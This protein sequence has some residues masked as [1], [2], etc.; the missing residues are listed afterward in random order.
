MPDE[1]IER[2]F[3][4]SSP[5]QLSVSNIDGSVEIRSGAD[6]NIHIVAVKH[7]NSGNA[8]RTQ[9]I[10]EQNA[11]GVVR[12]ATRFPEDG[13]GWLFG[14]KPCR[15]DY[16]ITAPRQCSI[17]VNGVSADA[18]IEGFDGKFDI[19]A[20]SGS[21]TLRGLTG[22]LHLHT[23]SGDV[24]GEHVSGAL[25]LDTVSGDIELRQSTLPA[26]NANTVSGRLDLET[27]LGSGP[28]R[29]GSVSGEVRLNVPADAACTVELNSLSGKVSAKAAVT[30]QWSRNGVHRLQV[31]NGGV[32]VHMQSVSGWLEIE[33]R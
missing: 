28:Y 31:H 14:S 10:I 9:I 18:L 4:V 17:D 33:S 7:I 16:I 32:D 8:E 1:T 11:A 13:L 26:V 27:S 20:V 22:P 15:V 29:F 2:D 21:V 24:S 30:E 6:N 3:T 5:A 25:M 19:N 23:V 12:A